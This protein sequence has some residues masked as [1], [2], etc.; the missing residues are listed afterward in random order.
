[1]SIHS[2]SALSF[3]V[4]ATVLRRGDWPM[5]DSFA[6]MKEVAFM[7]FRAPEHAQ[8]SQSTPVPIQQEMSGNPRMMRR[9]VE[10]IG[11]LHKLG[12]QDLVSGGLWGEL[13]DS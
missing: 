7:L 8:P 11:K 3:W 2:F 12:K 6:A 13:K 5:S 1:M 10:V 4:L 9:G